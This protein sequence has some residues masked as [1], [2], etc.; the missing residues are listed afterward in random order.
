M[1]VRGTLPPLHTPKSKA[2]R[3]S[4]ETTTLMI[5]DGSPPSS[6]MVIGRPATGIRNS[7]PSAWAMVS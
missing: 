6:R 3:A 7:R 2:M 5:S 4:T 1:K